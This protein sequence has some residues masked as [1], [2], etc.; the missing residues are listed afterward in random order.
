MHSSE[1]PNQSQTQVQPKMTPGGKL[2]LLSANRNET[3]LMASL[4]YTA[5][6]VQIFIHK[7]L[8]THCQIFTSGA[9]GNAPSR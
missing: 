9:N 8:V 4:I 7:F 2:I 3:R 5:R 1:H 6:S